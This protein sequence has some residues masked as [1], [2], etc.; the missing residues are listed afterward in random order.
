MPRSARKKSS[1]GIYH[2]MVRG[3]NKQQIFHDERD[4][5]KYLEIIKECKKQEAFQLFAYCCMQNHVHLLIRTYDD[6]ID[7]VMK[8]IG[9]RY[10][11]WYNCKYQRIGHL[12][13]DRFKSEPVET[14]SYFKTVVRYIIQN[15]LKAGLEEKIGD[16][17]WDSYWDLMNEEHGIIDFDELVLS[18]GSLESLIE[19]IHL[20]SD[21]IAMDIQDEKI[22]LTDEQAE[23]IYSNLKVEIT[24]DIKTHID[25]VTRQLHSAGLSVRQIVINTGIPK[26]KINKIILESKQ[27]TPS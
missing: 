26:S 13:Q 20:R 2:V 12:F 11:K 8:R 27:T 14:D 4:Y 25:T 21:D 18:F 16:Y 6:S 5:S 3:I 23:E 24:D 10:A 9:I 17:P 19:F 7:R 15:P 1:T 22:R